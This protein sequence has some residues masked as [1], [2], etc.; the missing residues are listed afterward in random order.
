MILR[1]LL[2]PVPVVDAAGMPVPSLSTSATGM[3]TV[4]YP[5]TGPGTQA[6]RLHWH[7]HIM[8][9]QVASASDAPLR[10]AP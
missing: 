4:V 10:L 3:A 6:R 7:W 5:P 1:L 9:L 8:L 2:V